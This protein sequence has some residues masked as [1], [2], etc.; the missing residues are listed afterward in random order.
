[1]V[2]GDRDYVV[3]AR[4]IGAVVHAVGAVAAGESAAVEP[5]HHRPFARIQTIGPYVE[6]QA[7]F[8]DGQLRY[9]SGDL[10]NL[11]VGSLGRFRPPLDSVLNASPGL[12]FHGR[13]ESV[14]PASGRAIRNAAEGVYLVFLD[15][16]ADLTVGGAGYRTLR[17]A[18]LGACG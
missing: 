15:H 10:G 7:I 1:M 11:G 17:R 4:H 2:D 5:E 3:F 12:G 9:G 6:M 14:G 16:T 8:A 18:V 13:H